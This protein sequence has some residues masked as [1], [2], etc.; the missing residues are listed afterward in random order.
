MLEALSESVLPFLAILNPF[1]MCLYLAAVIDELQWREFLRV[2]LSACLIAL[3]AF[4]VFALTG[5]RLLNFLGVR[6]EAARVFGGVIFFVVGYKYATTGFRAAEFLR[7]SVEELPSAIAM[8]FMIGAGTI[9]QSILMSRRHG[10]LAAI[11][12]IAVAIVV[13]LMAVVVFKLL[14]EHM[15]RR[16]ERLFERYVNILAR[17][18]GLII[19]AISAEMI[20]AGIHT[21]WD[22]SGPC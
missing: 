21:I 11:A 12:A 4:T 9:T 15:R 14:R 8:P 3:I 2:M 10:D 7:G 5:D 16:R 17:A 19:G 22:T 1:A 13:T 20:V 6:A 18:N